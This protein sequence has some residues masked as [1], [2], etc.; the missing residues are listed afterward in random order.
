[1]AIGDNEIVRQEGEIRLLKIEARHDRESFCV[2]GNGDT[3]YYKDYDD[4]LEEFNLR[5][6]KQKLGE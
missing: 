1:M 6:M 3:K 4:A 5:W 2:V